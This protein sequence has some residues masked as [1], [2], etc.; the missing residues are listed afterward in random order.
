MTAQLRHPQTYVD[1]PHQAVS[2]SGR[3]ALSIYFDANALNVLCRYRKVVVK[4]EHYRADAV[5]WLQ[6]RGVQVLAYLS[7]GADRSVHGE[8]LREGQALPDDTHPVDVRHAEWRARIEAQILGEKAI[9]N[10]FYLDHLDC[11]D[12]PIQIRAMLKLIRQVR[13]W[14]GPCY[15]LVNQGFRLLP[16]LGGSVNGVVID[17]LSTTWSDGYR[18][19]DR[20]ELEHTASLV[21]QARRLHLDVFGVDYAVTSRARRVALRRAEQ[22]DVPTFVSTRE[23]NLPGGLLP[24]MALPDQQAAHGRT[25]A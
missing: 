12:D 24:R 17:G 21:S 5:R 25:F 18:L 23:L 19:L 16:R 2:T 3:R 6:A 8:W 1:P 10:G 22:L 13:Q 4:P 9:F 14:A 15:L 20:A 7:L 11:A